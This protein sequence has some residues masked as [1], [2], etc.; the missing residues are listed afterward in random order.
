MEGFV[1][2]INK[3]KQFSI[4]FPDGIAIGFDMD[5]GPTVFSDEEHG[6]EGDQHGVL[7]IM[8]GSPH[9]FPII[10]TVQRGVVFSFFTQ[11]TAR[12]LHVSVGFFERV[13]LFHR[14]MKV[15]LNTAKI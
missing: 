10:I 7:K 1:T 2:I 13:F 6:I 9:I 8:T 15:W 11:N 5:T 3:C 4:P 14:A 12:I